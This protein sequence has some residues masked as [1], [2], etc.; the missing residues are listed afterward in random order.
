MYVYTYIVVV[1]DA[2]H[3]CIYAYC[4]SRVCGPRTTTP[5]RTT[6]R[7][8]SYTCPL[9]KHIYMYICVCIFI[10]VCMHVY[11]YMYVCMYICILYIYFRNKSHSTNIYTFVGL[12]ACRFPCIIYICIHAYTRIYIHIYTYIYIYIHVYTCTYVC[13]CIYIYIPSFRAAS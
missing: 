12:Y 7:S 8:E 1:A 3:V 9:Y 11:T 5:H 4:H 10:H 13:T 2:V 6:A